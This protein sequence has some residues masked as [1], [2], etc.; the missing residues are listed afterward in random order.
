M[1]QATQA[2]YASADGGDGLL[3]RV[4]FSGVQLVL[5]GVAQGRE[6]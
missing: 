1:A 4:A 5:G 6:H 3:C 2:A